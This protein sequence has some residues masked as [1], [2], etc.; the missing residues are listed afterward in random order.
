MIH[1]C[2]W[3]SMICYPQFYVLQR[4]SSRKPR[5]LV[6]PLRVDECIA[7]HRRCKTD[8]RQKNF[9]DWKLHSS[10]TLRQPTHW[11]KCQPL[12]KH[13]KLVIRKISLKGGLI[14]CRL[15]SVCTKKR[16]QDIMLGGK[17]AVGDFFWQQQNEVN[18]SQISFSLPFR[19]VLESHTFQQG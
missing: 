13:F 14:Q 16:S 3:H 12:K 11:L 9:Q 18:V 10:T 6:L 8:S 15:L 19:E 4:C 5:K 1:N 7:Q 17:E 2:P